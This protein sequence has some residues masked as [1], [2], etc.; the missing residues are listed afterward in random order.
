MP[1]PESSLSVVFALIGRLYQCCFAN[2]LQGASVRRWIFD[3]ELCFRNPGARSVN[4]SSC[5][6]TK[7][8][9]RPEV[10]TQDARR[11]EAWETVSLKVQQHISHPLQACLHNCN[12]IGH[13]RPTESACRRAVARVQSRY[14]PAG[15][16][17]P[18]PALYSHQ[19]KIFPNPFSWYRSAHL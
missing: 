2:V 3:H 19:N 11:S 6:H 7:Y 15:H 9:M 16:D 12:T 5:N 1:G 14:I 4:W 13:L 10:V 18:F 17:F 8:H